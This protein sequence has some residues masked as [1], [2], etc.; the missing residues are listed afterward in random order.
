[1]AR[2]EEM[3]GGR[4]RR[5]EKHWHRCYGDR[6]ENKSSDGMVICKVK[7]AEYSYLFIQ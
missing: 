3:E 7:D 5:I 4:V 6:T 2:R 1:M